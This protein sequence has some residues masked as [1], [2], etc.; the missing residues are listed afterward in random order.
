M[1]PEC[2]CHQGLRHP[3]E[4]LTDRVVFQLQSNPTEA[5]IIIFTCSVSQCPQ[6]SDGIWRLSSLLRSARNDGGPFLRQFRS[7]TQGIAPPEG[8][9][10]QPGFPLWLCKVAAIGFGHLPLGALCCWHQSAGKCPKKWERN[11]PVPRRRPP[12]LASARSN[13]CVLETVARVVLLILSHVIQTAT[14]GRFLSN[15]GV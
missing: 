2:L 1:C 6:A 14:R 5:G 9:A 13:A 11:S 4:R 12:L 8:I 3:A 15:V 7:A 10:S